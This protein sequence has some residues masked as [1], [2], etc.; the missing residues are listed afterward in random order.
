MA[1]DN[2]VNNRHS[3]SHSIDKPAGER[4]KKAVPLF[5]GHPYAVILKSDSQI[6]L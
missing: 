5:V 4:L 1:L 6:L 3:Q 2:L